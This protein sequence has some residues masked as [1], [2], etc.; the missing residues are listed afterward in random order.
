MNRDDSA[1]QKT[2]IAQ[3]RTEIDKMVTF[4][5]SQMPNRRPTAE[6]SRLI[7]FADRRQQAQETTPARY[8]P[9]RQRPETSV[10][11]ES[12]VPRPFKRGAAPAPFGAPRYELI[13]NAGSGGG[14][15]RRRKWPASVSDTGGTLR[16]GFDLA[17]VQML[18][19][20]QSAPSGSEGGA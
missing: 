3:S 13:E 10:P 11:C 1:S 17:C 14:L 7:A 6:E 20:D 5:P 12:R 2:S 9:T 18:K 4:V 15:G 8:A 19:F 16:R